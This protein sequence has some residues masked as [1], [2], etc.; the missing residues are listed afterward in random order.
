MLRGKFP[1]DFALQQ[2][3]IARKLLAEEAKGINFGEYIKMQVKEV[4]DAV[5]RCIIADMRLRFAL[6]KFG[7]AELLMTANRYMKSWTSGANISIIW[8][9]RKMNPKALYQISY[10]L[11]V[12][13][14]RKRTSALL[15]LWVRDSL[16]FFLKNSEKVLSFRL[17]GLAASMR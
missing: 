16:Y 12:V 15:Y 1:N 2:V 17:T 8:R 3:H 10:G 5:P 14:S 9:L 7:K 11:Y 4:K 6:P 13:S